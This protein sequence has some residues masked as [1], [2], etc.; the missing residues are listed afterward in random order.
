MSACLAN[1]T[2]QARIWL[3]W[4]HSL[5]VSMVSSSEQHITVIVN[6]ALASNFF[7]TIAH[8]SCSLAE[9]RDLWNYIVDFAAMCDAP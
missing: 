7:V 1:T 9:R 2:D 5:N 4:H 3:L 6:S 8:A